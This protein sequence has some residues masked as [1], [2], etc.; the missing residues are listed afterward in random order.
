M[1]SMI[2]Q[3]IKALFGELAWLSHHSILYFSAIWL[4]VLIDPNWTSESFV[5]SLLIVV[6]IILIALIVVSYFCFTSHKS[7]LFGLPVLTVGYFLGFSPITSTLGIIHMHSFS[8][9]FIA[10]HVHWSVVA[11]IFT[12][13]SFAMQNIIVLIRRIIKRK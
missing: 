10:D 7:T 9:L 5:I 12:L 13:F 1:K 6:P 2:M 8:Y 11:I 3:V 4:S